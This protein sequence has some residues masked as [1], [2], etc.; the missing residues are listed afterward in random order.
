MKT[1]IPKN[2]LTWE[3]V[4]NRLS[5]DHE[6]GIL[7][8]KAKIGDSLPIQQWNKRYAGKIA[9][10]EGK[11]GYRHITLGQHRLLAH[12]LVFLLSRGHWPKLLCD[13]IDQNKRNNAPANLR[14]ATRAENARNRSHHSNNT[15]GHRN[16]S[17]DGRGGWQVGI[18]I[19]GKRKG[20]GHFKDFERAC[21]AADAATPTS[22]K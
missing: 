3:E 17:R 16:V 13:H 12:R 7:R 6:T 2:L 22:R 4:N 15:S 10:G 21:L 9:G 8:W 20:I 19:N 5:F 14:E 1:T 11:T 18:S